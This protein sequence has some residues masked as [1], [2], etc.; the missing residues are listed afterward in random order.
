MEPS[1]TRCAEGA[2][3]CSGRAGCS[4]PASAGGL[5]ENSNFTRGNFTAGGYDYGNDYLTT[6]NFTAGAGSNS[7]RNNSNTNKRSN[8]KSQVSSTSN[9]LTCSINYDKLIAFRL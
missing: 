4:V 6:G 8:K 3:D 9:Y 1:H 2:G 7:S 5:G